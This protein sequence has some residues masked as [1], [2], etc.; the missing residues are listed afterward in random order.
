MAIT[1]L[2]A[3]DHKI[4]REGL[5]SLIHNQPGMEVI[6]EADD[7]ASAIQLAHK[8]KPD[9]IVMD[10]NMPGTDGIDATYRISKELPNTK[11]I[12]LS[13]YPKRSFVTE[14]LKAGASGYVLKEKAFDDLTK[15]INAVMAGDTYLCS[16]I[17]SLVVNDYINKQLLNDSPDTQTP[18]TKR[19]QQILRIIVE[20]QNTK[21]IARALHISSKTVDTHRRNIMQKLKLHSLPELTKYAIRSGISPIEQ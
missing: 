2:L 11:I 16:K 5:C 1:I 15:A 17:T 9:I 18:L 20:G 6:G 3:D 4:L 21:Q 8:L 10:I 13:M 19:E 14:M 7:G 12:A